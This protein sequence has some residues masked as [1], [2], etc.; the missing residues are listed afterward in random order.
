MFLIVAFVFHRAS[1]ETFLRASR[2]SHEERVSEGDIQTS[3]LSEVEGALGG[4]SASIRLK[5]LEAF[6]S[7]IF[8]A[9]PKNEKGYLGHAT[10]RYA[11]HRL[12]V[13]RHGW[14]IKGLDAAGGHR[15]TTSSAGVLK[16]HVPAY[17]QDLF[18]KRLGDR[19]F[20]L[21]ELTVLAATIEHVI[22]NEAIKR[23]GDA[24]KA[25]S[26]LPTSLMTTEQADEVLDTYMASYIIGEDLSTMNTSDVDQLKTAMPDMYMD[27]KSTQDFVRSTRRN[28]TES[29]STAQQK[30]SAGLDFSLVAR[31]AER[32]GEGF[33]AHQDESCRQMKTSLVA[34]EEPGTGRVR[35]S[36]FYRPAVGG[37]WQ[38]QESVSYLRELGALDETDAQKL[39]VIIPNYI[40]SPSNCIA[41][42]SFYSVCCMDECEGLL[43]HIERQIAAPE[44]STTRIA[45]LVAD[46][47]SRKLPQSLLDRLGDIA[48]THDGV[49]PLHGRLFAQW[50][51]HAF[52]HECPYPH[53]SG[54]TNPQTP[55]DWLAST[56]KD[57][58]ATKEE[59]DIH[60]SAASASQAPMLDRD[61]H[62]EAIAP[63]SPEEELLVSRVAQS[64]APAGSSLLFVVRHAVMFALAVSFAMALVHSSSSGMKA[65]GGV[66]KDEKFMV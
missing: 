19:G 35:L 25:H 65:L 61:F 32:A 6:L 58:A 9:L 8:N 50:M 12:F 43:G 16:E 47:S 54:T 24:F 37:E 1:A 30:A 11:L 51:H 62:V 63:W 66:T 59:M 4:G 26:F 3:L 44:A 14:V 15:N 21:H 17:V 55:D 13:Q 53:L 52:P 48:A 45:S 36:D 18:E 22:H 39:R 5:K 64:V 28:V 60:V 34:M 56:G 31:V 41:S 10:V 46:L 20:G 27:W 40:S 2:T 29:E 23:L 57:I 42:S 33:G 49:V 38:F 7:P